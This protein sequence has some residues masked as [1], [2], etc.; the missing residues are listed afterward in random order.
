VLGTVPCPW[1]SALEMVTII[2]ID[3]YYKA[4]KKRKLAKS[5]RQ[6]SKAKELPSRKTL[7]I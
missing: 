7:N 4:S 3:S 2:H 1:E 5:A 6:N